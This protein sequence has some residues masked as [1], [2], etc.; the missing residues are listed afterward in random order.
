VP[1][2]DLDSATAKFGDLKVENP[3]GEK[4]GKVDGFIIHVDTAQPYYVVVDSGGWFSSKNYLV[5][6]AFA[7]LD[8]ERHLMQADLSR[9]RIKRFPGFDKDEFEK[10]SD[11]ELEQFARSTASACSVTESVFADAGPWP[12]WQTYYRQPDWWQ[13]HYSSEE[14]AGADGVT[15]GAALPKREQSQADQQPAMVRDSAT[16]RRD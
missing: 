5:P 11:Q 6:I 2:N 8:P 14:R 15:A 1:A 16:P 13:S 9:E 12:E 3:E 7:R 4:L 10:L